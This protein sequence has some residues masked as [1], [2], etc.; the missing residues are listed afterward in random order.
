MDA[1]EP[2]TDAPY[3]V[4]RRDEEGAEDETGQAHVLIAELDRQRRRSD[5][6]L[7]LSSALA[8]LQD[9]TEIA[10]ALC[11][12]VTLASGAPFAMVGRRDPGTSRFVVAATEGLDV[13]QVSLISAALRTADRPSLRDL[14]VGS[15]TA[16]ASGEAVGLGMGIE[17]AMGAPILIDG[18]TEGFIALGAPPGSAV[19][20]DEWEELLTAFAALTATA[21]ARADAVGALARQRDLLASEVEERNRNLRTVIDELRRASDAKTAFLANVSHELRTPLTAI[22]GF[23][24]ILATGMDG[25]LNPDQTRDVET[26]QRSSRHLLDLIDDLIDVASIE[27]GRMQLI[28][29]PVVAD[30]VIR[31]AI[32]TIRPLAVAKRISLEV[33]RH[34]AMAEGHRILVSADRGRLREIVLN[35]LS[36]AVK[37]TPRGGRV[38]VG[39]AVE[40]AAVT[41]DVARA[42]VAIEIRDSG[43]GISPADQERIFEKFVRIAP[44]AT[45][46]TGLGLTISRELARLHGGDLTVAST[47][48]LGSTFTIRVPL[49][50]ER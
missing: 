7:A 24:E 39:V 23:V 13:H 29:G 40:P 22:L 8:G 25:P 11:A 4:T 36:N 30:E 20:A 35:I 18:E 32:D 17:Q 21:L 27:G 34:E 33:D 19:L 15:T 12:F 38:V 16:R 28:V 37:F 5:T 6:L 48:G 9:G 2:R 42:M 31:D 46:G 41:G 10:R 50:A 49:A 1:I 43:L 44:A 14:L 26:I 45:P 47:V 3:L